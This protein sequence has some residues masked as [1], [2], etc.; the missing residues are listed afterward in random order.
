MLARRNARPPLVRSSDVFRQGMLLSLLAIKVF[1]V[2]AAG[3]L[4]IVPEQSALPKLG[5]KKLND[6]P[7]R[8]R[9]KSIGL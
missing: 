7:E 5:K 9:E 2:S 3:N 6:I 4:I 1:A 8:L